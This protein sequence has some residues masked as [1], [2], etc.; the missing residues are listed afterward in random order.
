MPNNVRMK[1]IK[2]SSDES[3]LILYYLII[4]CNIFIVKK[5][6]SINLQEKKWF[7]YLLQYNY[8]LYFNYITAE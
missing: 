6:F 7:I 5:T 8:K 3:V 2:M 1:Q 4:I